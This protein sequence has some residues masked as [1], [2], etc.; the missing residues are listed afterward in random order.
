MTGENFK[1]A[2][3]PVYDNEIC[4]YKRIDGLKDFLR[5]RPAGG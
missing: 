2:P 5:R 3:A 1:T 4:G